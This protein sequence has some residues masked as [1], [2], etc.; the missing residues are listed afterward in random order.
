KT[1][2]T[3]GATALIVVPRG[4]YALLGSA[5]RKSA[6]PTT[7]FVHVAKASN[8]QPT[9]PAGSSRCITI[10][11]I[12]RVDDCVNN[13]IHQ[14]QRRGVWRIHTVIEQSRDIAVE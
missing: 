1:S 8:N 10:S 14:G 9:I 12:I 6:A 13:A 4:I 7:M 5:R 3:R 11:C 2:P